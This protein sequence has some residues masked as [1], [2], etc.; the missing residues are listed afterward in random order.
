MYEEIDAQHYES[1]CDNVASSV[2]MYPDILSLLQTVSEH[3]NITAVV[4]TSGLKR[5]W[6]KVLGLERLPIKVIGGDRLS[7]SF[8]VTPEVKSALV[9]RLQDVHKQYV[10]AFGDSPLDLGMLKQAD[11]AVVVVGNMDTRSKSMESH[12]FTAIDEGLKAHQV[13]LPSTVPPRVDTVRLPELSR[14]SNSW[15]ISVGS[16]LQFVS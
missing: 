6:Q 8:V 13:R 7:Y 5:V 16:V 3:S 11:R 15:S 4:V 14:F 12:I 1:L 10:W 2:V 9:K